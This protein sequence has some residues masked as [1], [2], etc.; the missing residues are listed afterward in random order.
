MSDP[1]GPGV[2]RR[3]GAGPEPLRG[4]QAMRTV[5]ALER[6]AFGPMSPPELAASVRIDPRTTRRPLARL[7]AEDYVRQTGDRRHRYQLTLRLAAL[8]RQA[9]AHT[10]WLHTAAPW[11]ANLAARTSHTAHLWIPSYGDVACVLHAHPDGAVPEPML[12]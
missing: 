4:Y 12:R 9:I 10:A 8:G 2:S 1:D 7:A 3:R 5:R 6:L 11:V